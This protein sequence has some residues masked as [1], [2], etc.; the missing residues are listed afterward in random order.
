LQASIA[1]EG[2]HALMRDFGATFT[3]TAARAEMP[4]RFAFDNGA[5]SRWVDR[6]LTTLGDS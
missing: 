2:C 4:L 3:Y 6:P 5:L 1:P